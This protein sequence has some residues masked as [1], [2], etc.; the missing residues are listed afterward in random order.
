M[1][2][3]ELYQ[4]MTALSQEGRPFVLA[5]IVE[6]QGSSPREVGAKVLVEPDGTTIETIGGGPLEA[7]VVADAQAAL[8]SGVSGVRTYRLTEEG[9]QALGALCGGEVKVFHEV[10]APEHSLLIVGAGYI[11]QSL[12][13]LARQLD[14]RIT[15]VDSRADMLTEERLSEADELVLAEPGQI[16]ELCRIDNRTH[17]VV[18][19]HSHLHDE[20]AVFTTVSSPAAYIGMIGSARKV[21]KVMANLAARGI[22]EEQLKR[23][24]SPIG[25]DIGAQTP[26][27]L[28]LSI[29]AEIVAVSHGLLDDRKPR[30]RRAKERD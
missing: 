14:Y 21:R 3:A 16:A 30:V 8:E 26:A 15:V 11:G 25:L 12:C 20:E 5:T 13:R 6:L 4:V 9:D 22:P 10:H 17:V 23:V 28:A 2:A 7:R 29:M 27:E 18:V 1:K 19:T 24:H